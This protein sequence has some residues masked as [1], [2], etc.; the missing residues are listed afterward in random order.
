MKTLVAA[1]AASVFSCVSAQAAQIVVPS[2]GSLANA[3]A[4][5][6]P[7]DEIV[8]Q[9]GGIYTGNLVLPEKGGVITIRSAAELPDRRIGPADRAL[10]PILSSGTS[11]AP[12]RITGSHWRLTGLAFRANA[13]GEGN[14]IEILGSAGDIVI[15]RVLIEGGSRGQK[16]GIAMNGGGAVTVMRSHISNIWTPYAESQAIAAWDG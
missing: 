6:V 14:T 3:V 12:I 4:Q 5:A 7:G 2:G 16:R 11:M 9:A 15:D 8:L 1:L 10:L 13:N